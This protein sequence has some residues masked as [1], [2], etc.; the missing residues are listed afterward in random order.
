[1]RVI[2]TG[3]LAQSLPGFDGDFPIGF[4]RQHQNNLSCIN[5]GLD[6]GHAFTHALI[7]HPTVQL[8]QRLHFMVGIPADA[9]AAISQF[10]QKRT[11]R[12]KL[13]IEIGVVPLHH[14]NLRHGLTGDRVYLTLFPVRHIKRLSNLTRRIVQDGHQD[15]IFLNTQ[16]FRCYL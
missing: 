13:L 2:V 3:L 9:L 5:I 14:R 16:Y 6:F 11:K 15:N 12:S 4:G 10:F 8:P 7:G 1:M